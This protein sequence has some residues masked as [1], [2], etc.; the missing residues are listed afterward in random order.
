MFLD[1]E[2][3]VISWVEAAIWKLHDVLSFHSHYSTSSGLK[4]NFPFFLLKIMHIDL[5]E[6]Q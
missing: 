6:L 3:M 4:P 2:S 5:E 1:I